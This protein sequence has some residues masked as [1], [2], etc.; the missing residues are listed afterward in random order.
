MKRYRGVRDS[1]AGGARVYVHDSDTTLPRKLDPRNDLLDHSPDG[2]QWG[3]MGSGPAQLALALLCDH[4]GD[5][6]QAVLYH[7]D[8]KRAW[9][10]GIH[11]DTWWLKSDHLAAI[12]DEIRSAT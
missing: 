8:F 7:Q 2:F 3:Y 10:A 11:A 4:L 6:D 5:D 1:G 12:L 9:V